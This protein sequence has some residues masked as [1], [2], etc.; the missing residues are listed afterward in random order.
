MYTNHT[1]LCICLLFISL[2]ILALSSTPC[3]DAMTTNTT[4]ARIHGGDEQ[5]YSSGLDSTDDIEYSTD[6]HKNTKFP[7]ERLF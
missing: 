5:Q 3:C 4:K 7:P 2:I 1:R 6:E